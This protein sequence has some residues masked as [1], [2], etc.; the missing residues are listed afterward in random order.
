M[1]ALSTDQIRQIS[2]ELHRARIEVRAIEPLKA[3]IP[4]LDI[5]G[6]Y[7][8]SQQLL[9]QRLANGERIVGHKIGV[10]SHAVM[11]M[12]G[13]NQPDYGTLT[14]RMAYDDG[15]AILASSMIAPRAEGEIAFILKR[16]LVGPGIT[17]HQVLAATEAIA[18]CFEVVDSRI[19][20]W[21]I[22]IEDT[23][24]DNASAAAFVLGKN[25]ISPRGFDLTTCGMV[26]EKNGEIVAT[27]A[28][29]AALRSPLNCVAWLA[30]R[31]G[32]FGT[33]LRAGEI[34]LSGALVPLLPV[35]AGDH[36]RVRVGGLGSAEMSFS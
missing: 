14:D 8:I 34:I 16:D 28:G 4:D 7:A 6:A 30:N 11:Q 15:S 1:S 22:T 3:R 17:P 27:G 35:S 23:V 13:V 9:D 18:V 31:L 26:L 29:A 12:L 5:A 25:L 33:P 32:Q 2:D 19:A 24:A 10:T 36:I 20:D 21:K